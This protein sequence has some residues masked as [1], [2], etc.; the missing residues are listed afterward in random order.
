M[1]EAADDADFQP[2]DEGTAMGFQ[3]C[4]SKGRRFGAAISVLALLAAVP[5]AEARQA[6][7]FATFAGVWT[8]GGSVVLTNGSQERVR[9]KA[10][11]A[12]QQGGDALQIN[13]NCASD[14][15]KVQVIGNVIAGSDGRISGTWQ[16]LTREISG[17]V[18]GHMP[19]P[20]QLQANLEG[21]PYTI[22]LS[23]NTRGNLQTIAMQVLG[24][25]VQSVAI[26]LRRS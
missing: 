23:F 8:G 11:Y 18:V 24:S 3:F 12:P 20:S 10:N 19:S 6:S 14:S 16:E 26:S 1:F 7:I 13:L 2:H 9:C 25:D 5:V 4:R 22:Q 15:Y 21:A 17:N